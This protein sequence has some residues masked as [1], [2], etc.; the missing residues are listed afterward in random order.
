[1]V[2]NQTRMLEERRKWL[3][4]MLGYVKPYN[5]VEFGCGSG[6]ALEVLSGHFPNSTIIGVDRS[7]ERL[8]M[9]YE[10]KLKNVVPMKA[11]FTQ[12][13]FPDKTFDTAIFVGSLHEV[14]SAVGR[15]KLRDTLAVAGDELKD[16][17]VVIIQDFLK[18]NKK[19][20]TL[21]F[22]NEQTRKIFSRF[23][24]EFTQRKVVFEEIKG[25]VKLD[26]ADAVEFI[27]KYRSPTE[28][29]WR[30]EMAET[31]F[32]FSE[33]EYKETAEKAGFAVK[34]VAELSK[35]KAFWSEIKEDIDFNYPNDYLWIQLVLTKRI[36]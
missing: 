32:F 18:P 22:H 15:E 12:K 29:D 30:E 1:M 33:Q 13:L 4:Y 10:R 5:I 35:S 11:D 27:S 8:D 20:V 23:V 28:E 26:V 19:P 14:F 2:Q 31:H 17:G 25:G 16:N 34:H 36:S 9:V 21:Y 3:D 6:F 7:I 24:R